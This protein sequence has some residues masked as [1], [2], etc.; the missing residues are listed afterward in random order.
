MFRSAILPFFLSFAITAPV[1]A[2]GTLRGVVTG[3]PDG[4]TLYGATVF[5]M[6]S[7]LGASTDAEGRYEIRRIPNGTVQVRISFI[8]YETI[9]RD[10]EIKNNETLVLDFA[11]TSSSV[12]G[13]EVE[14][15]A[16]A[17][18]Q[19]A[20]INQQRA[21]NTIVNVVSEEKI[22]EL[23]DAN[24]AES[25]GRLPGVSLTRS[26]GEAN[27]V[28]L[29]GLSDKYL[30]V[31]VDG[32]RL[33]TTDAQARGLD[34][35]AISQS[36]LSGI[37][38]YK[39]VTP[40]KDADA[41]AGSINLV[42]RRAP[43]TPEFR[44]TGMG[45]YNQIMN[46]YGQYDVNARYSRRFLNN[47][48]GMQVNGNVESKIRS[49]ERIDISYT[50]VNGGTS[51]FI[52]DLTLRFTDEQRTRRGFGSIVDINTPDRGNIKVSGLYSSTTRDLLTHE[53][54]YPYSVGSV[55]YEF[56]NTERQIDLY[57]GSIIGENRLLGFD[58][59]WVA[60]YSRSDAHNPFDYR[61][62]FVEPSSNTSGMMAKPGPF[63]DRAERL[64]EYAFNNFEAA[65]ISN[66][67]DYNQKNTEK[68]L[69][70][71]FDI[72]RDYVMAS[73]LSG[74]FKF[75]GKYA[76]KDRTNQNSRAYAPYYLGYWRAF[77][78]SPDGTVVPKNFGGSYFEEF[79]EGFLANPSFNLPSFSLFLH[80]DPRSKFILDDFNMNPLMS[81]ERLRQWYQINRN[82]INQAGTNTEY[83]DDPSTEANTYDITESVNAGYVMNTFRMGQMVT[84]IVGARVENEHHNYQN[85]WA[86]GQIGGFPIPVGSTKDTSSTYNETIVLPHLH[87]NIQP[88]SFLNIRFAAYR[89]LARPDFNMRLTSHFAWRDAETGGSR[90]LILGNPNLKTAKAWNFE[91]NTAIYSHKLGLISVSVFYKHIDDMYHMLNGLATTGDT[92]IN[93]LGLDWKSPHR[94]SYE[95]TVPYNSPDASIIRGIEF[96]HQIQFSW[97]PG[98]LRNVVLSYN[99]STVRSSTT[100]IG[101]TI[102]TTFVPDPLF[103][104]RPVFSVRAVQS[105]QK[106]QNQPDLFGNVS[107]GYDIGGFSGRVSMFH[108]SEY[109]RSYSASGLSHRIAGA[110]TR[111]DLALTYKL[112]RNMTL[113]ANVNN[114]TNIRESDIRHNETHGYKI[115]RS[116]ERYGMSVD[117]GVRITL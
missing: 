48:I 3:Q 87:V 4:G 77:E 16:Q 67:W 86:P 19:L 97:L 17:L 5:I 112:N 30:N 84:A 6:G 74:V 43:E 92:L 98:L 34:L 49:N 14:V 69:S 100:V 10:V 106:L 63:T 66:G 101:S 113:A 12:M 38:L 94:G 73:Y 104:Q 46:A 75:G 79:Y 102:D 62:E 89:A 42:T 35:S 8:G 59:N 82:G 2:D 72:S 76:S 117:F 13:A 58:V 40:D 55:T 23:P 39:A 37:E 51:Y 29:R 36:S 78:R 105:T 65:S 7:S 115:P 83:H 20:A 116:T 111:Y 80:P 54:N 11:L 88:L 44:L 45:G 109:Y 41:I 28:I 96:E 15:S 71:R 60:S 1:W 70:G 9:F 93:H 61:L 95:L 114:L 107:L 53:R 47:L 32:V 85:T 91:V 99:V 52:S 18:G 50:D 90:I 27:K 25:I 81:R 64:A 108:Q 68:E 21:S 56:R 22:K 57:S 110:Y 33:P 103:G 31:T 24:A 26:G